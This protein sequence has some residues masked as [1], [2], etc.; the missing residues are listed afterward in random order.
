M[1][2]TI[3]NFGNLNYYLPHLY[4]CIKSFTSIKTQNTLIFSRGYFIIIVCR[5]KKIFGCVYWT[6]TMTHGPNTST[7]WPDVFQ[8]T[9][10]TRS[11]ITPKCHKNIY[12]QIKIELILVILLFFHVRQTMYRPLGRKWKCDDQIDNHIECILT[13]PIRLHNLNLPEYIE[14]FFHLSNTIICIKNI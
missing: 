10:P 9:R 2:P 4:N 6:I 14:L 5:H 8:Q 11:N 13:K 3:F 1:F 12:C 7:V